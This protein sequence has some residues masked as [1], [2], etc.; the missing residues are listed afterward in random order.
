V[1]VFF[2]DVI[3]VKRCGY[4]AR[5]GERHG[6]MKNGPRGPFSHEMLGQATLN[7]VGFPN[8]PTIVNQF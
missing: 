5:F 2:G 6:W 7:V 3:F 8:V 1:H 4:W